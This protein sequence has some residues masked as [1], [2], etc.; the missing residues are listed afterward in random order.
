MLRE[1]GVKHSIMP[2]RREFWLAALVGLL[3]AAAREMLTRYAAHGWRQITF[4]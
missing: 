3:S 4:A 2:N 1:V